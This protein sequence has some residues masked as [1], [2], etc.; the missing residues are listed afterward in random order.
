MSSDLHSSGLA[1]QGRLSLLCSN[2]AYESVLVLFPKDVWHLILNQRG[3]TGFKAILRLLL[4]CTHIRNGVEAAIGD[5]LQV[6]REASFDAP[7]RMW[8][9]DSIYWAR[10]REFPSASPIHYD[11]LVEVSRGDTPRLPHTRALERLE[12]DGIIGSSIPY[13]RTTSA[14][15]A[16]QGIDDLKWVRKHGAPWDERTPASLAYKGNVPGL[17][18]VHEQSC[19]INIDKV[20]IEAA[21][22]N[23]AEV[24]E[25]SVR[26]GLT[27][28]PS[29]P[30]TEDEEHIWEVAA[31]AAATR[32]RLLVLIWLEDAGFEFSPRHAVQAAQQGCF[33]AMELVLS[34][35]ETKPEREDLQTC[36]S[37]AA[38]KGD[39]NAFI[40]LRYSKLCAFHPKLLDVAAQR[41]HV[42]VIHWAR[43]RGCPWT[44]Q[45]AKDTMNWFRLQLP[46]SPQPIDRY[47]PVSSGREAGA[48]GLD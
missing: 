14:R 13:T 37:C 48:A 30:L 17:Q 20:I 40:W 4:T 5:E 23:K 36:F 3:L 16:L 7:S 38:D 29:G 31:L 2:A 33:K 41:G 6:L 25:W 47:D 18:W 12:V 28:G 34:R 32:D 27:N 10:Q 26:T 44:E 35:R 11:D 46:P 22:A 45:A 15:A 9:W 21:H 39:L 1:I 8:C 19:P 24:L 43:V 42:A